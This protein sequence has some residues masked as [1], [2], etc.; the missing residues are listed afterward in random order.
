[1]VYT[2]KKAKDIALRNS[3]AFPIKSSANPYCFQSILSYDTKSSKTIDSL[4]TTVV[5]RRFPDPV[6]LFSIEKDDFLILNLA[7]SF[8]ISNFYISKKSCNFIHAGKK[9]SKPLLCNNTSYKICGVVTDDIVKF[10]QKYRFE[11]FYC[12]YLPSELFGDDLQ[13][14][15]VEIK[16]KLDDVKKGLLEDFLG[17]FANPA[18]EFDGKYQRIKKEFELLRNEK[19]AFESLGYFEKLKKSQKS[20]K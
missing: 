20:K 16:I 5:L 3:F 18:Q 1:M 13:S 15:R 12:S 19:K 6:Y 4:S 11:Y 2:R 17:L 10:C 14:N 9:L 7:T 8:R